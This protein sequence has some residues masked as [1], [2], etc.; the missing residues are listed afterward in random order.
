VAGAQPSTEQSNSE[1]SQAAE[2]NPAVTLVPLATPADD[3]NGGILRYTNLDTLIP[4]RPRTDVV[5]YT[6]KPGDNLFS[7]AEVYGL[8]PETLLWSNFETLKDNPQLLSID[9]VLYILP[10]DGAY[11]QWQAGDTLGEIAAY[12][13]VEPQA[14]LEYPGNDLDLTLAE[15][16]T[17][18]IEPDEWIIVPGGSRPLKDWGPPAI[19]RS[20]PASAQ[21][22]GSGHCGSVYEGP[23]G[24][25]AF[26][27]PTTE[28]TIS[29][30][31]YSAIHRGIDIGGATGN[32]VFAAD[33]GV[34]VYAGWSNYGY[35][36]LIV[37]DHGNG[38]QTAYAHLSSIGV[39]CGQGVGQ[40]T[41]IGG[42]G[43]T[44]NSTGSHLHF[45]MVFNGTKPNP[46]DFV[47]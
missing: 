12:Y 46:F 36:N 37:V 44:G 6:V 47:Q 28:H 35:G 23:I 3:F 15:T 31:N 13:S 24:Y 40:G 29:G 32:A 22:Y 34:V 20:N 45:E 11:Y 18:G 21:Y 26:V 2:T 5:T 8:K 25:G 9:Q 1:Q 33:S 41:M 30:Y 16:E 4:N 42:V 7:I 27:W 43:S 10:E 38:W 19:T 17:G 14:I 39:S